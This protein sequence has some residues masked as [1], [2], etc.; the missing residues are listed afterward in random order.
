MFDCLGL[1]YSF[2]VYFF[3]SEAEVKLY[4]KYYTNT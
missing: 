1:L 2:F 3:T 4:S